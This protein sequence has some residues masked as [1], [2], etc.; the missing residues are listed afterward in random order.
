MR[1]ITPVFLFFLLSAFFLL[2]CS[3]KPEKSLPGRWQEAT[4]RE[5][6]EFFKDGTFRGTMIWDLTNAPVDIS[7]TYIV[8]GDMVGITVANPAELTPMTWK[9]AFSGSDELTV[10]FQQGGALK[11]DGGSA[12]YRRAK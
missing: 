6:I 11:R 3:A 4:G 10:V 8:K 1:R 7:G 9:I 5:A 12:K 2:S